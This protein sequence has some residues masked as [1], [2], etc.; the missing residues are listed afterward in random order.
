MVKSNGYEPLDDHLSREIA[1]LQAASVLDCMMKVAIR[2]DN[3]EL[4]SHVYTGWVEISDKLTYSEDEPVQEDE[5]TIGF[6]V[7]NGGP[8]I[9]GEEII[10]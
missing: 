2:T 1:L 4:M 8:A 7:V 3:P 9:I 6:A 10:S 5:K